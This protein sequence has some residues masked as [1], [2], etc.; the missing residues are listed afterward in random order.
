[1]ADA[2]LL[3]VTG[4]K[5]VNLFGRYTHEVC[6]NRDERVTILHGPNGIGKTAL[7]RL[8]AGALSGSFEELEKYPFDVFQIG[9]SDNSL[10]S[11]SK[12]ANRN[13][14]ERITVSL[15]RSG[16]RV[17]NDTI[18]KKQSGQF[19][20]FPPPSYADRREPEW[21]ERLRGRVKVHFIKTDRLTVLVPR[22][23]EPMRF[24]GRGDQ[25]AAAVLT[26][27]NDLSNRI[28]VNLADYAQR[29]QLLD[30]TLP[31]RLL[32]GV[33]APLTIDE[34]RDRMK[35]LESTRSRLQRNG[36]IDEDA[37][38]AGTSLEGLDDANRAL[39]TLYVA[40]TESKLQVLEAFS[41]RIEIFLASMNRK[42]FDKKAS[43]DRDKGLIVETNEGKPL[44]LDSLSSGEQHELVLLYDLLFRVEANTLVLID[45][46]ELSLHV[47]W[48][49]DFVPDLLEA[50][51]TVG[52]DVI[53]A[54]H[55][56]SIVGGRHDLM[57]ALSPLSPEEAHPLRQAS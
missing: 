45:E 52:Y 19:L 9:F 27:A 21:L 51:A 28:S 54:T 30:S 22:P 55:S 36:L 3:R 34:L 35:V 13:A 53:L 49:R 4:I 14:E 48:Q 47:T 31:K 56:P 57:A 39:M 29:A 12:P 50:V 43:I 2:K 38:L 24:L 46:P 33:Q 6:L 41:R 8:V 11:F 44:E 10:V 40:D 16:S 37:A 5:V 18:E 25:Y 15:E 20:E 32:Q 26:C 17:E 7:L 1:M 42:F 23:T